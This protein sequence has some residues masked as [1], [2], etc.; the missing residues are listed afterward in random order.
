MMDVLRVMSLSPAPKKNSVIFCK[1]HLFVCVLALTV[2]KERRGVS[3][4]N[5]IHFVLYSV[6]RR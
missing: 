6:Q 1:Y 5:F 3:D 2:T 4:P